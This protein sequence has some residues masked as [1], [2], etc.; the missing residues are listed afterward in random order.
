VITA[1][2]IAPEGA[3]ARALRSARRVFDSFDAVVAHSEYGAGR[4]RDEVGV[5]ADR[6]R[7]I[8][9]G[10]FDYLTHSEAAPLPDELAE[11]SAPVVLAFGLIRDYKGTD[12]LLEAF[13][14]IEG[15]ELWIVGM[16][17]MPLEPLYEL[18]GRCRAT[19]R[20]V[21]RFITDAEIPSYFRRADL[22]VL[23]YTEAEQSGVLYTGL[24]FGKPML[25]SAVGGF[26]EIAAEGAA[27]LVPPGDSNALA[28]ALSELLGDEDERRELGEAAELAAARRYSWDS[29]AAQTLELY[30]EL[31]G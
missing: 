4:L 25:L 16:P 10:A 15:A 29:I 1:H 26:P 31:L 8:P 28:A 22:L 21:P 12:A 14:E 17:R 7:V 27:R 3:G 5:K 19:V 6:V 24:A 2:H 30:R 11:V 23:P 18:A 20:F 9:H 13:R